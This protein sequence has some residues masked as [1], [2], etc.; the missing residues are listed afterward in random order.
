[1][2]KQLSLYAEHFGFEKGWI[3]KVLRLLP[4]YPDLFKR[5]DKQI[6][7][8]IG[9]SKIKGL[10]IWLKGME[11]IEGE[12]K[13]VKLTPLGQLIKEY[14]EYVN[15]YGSWIVLVHNLS[16]SPPTTLL[17]STGFSTK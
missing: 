12:G 14:D 11:I 16:V 10:N 3:V 15:K 1:M 5:A 8:G 9:T 2:I 4:Q 13:M 6:L 7:L 17:V